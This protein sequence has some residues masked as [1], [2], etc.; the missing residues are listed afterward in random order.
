MS[1]REDMPRMDPMN[2]LDRVTHK[3]LKTASGV[4]LIYQYLM[5]GA[6]SRY[7]LYSNSDPFII[8]I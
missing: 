3:K 8:P 2:E 5:W 6:Q 7:Y 4:W 1:S